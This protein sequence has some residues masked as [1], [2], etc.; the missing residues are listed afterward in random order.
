MIHGKS[1]KHFLGSDIKHGKSRKPFLGS[2]I[3]HG[4]VKTLLEL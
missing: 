2:D 4:K 3:K 1:K